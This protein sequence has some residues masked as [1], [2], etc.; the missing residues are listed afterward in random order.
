MEEASAP[1]PQKLFKGVAWDASDGRWRARV[2]LPEVQ[3]DG[4][5]KSVT[6]DAGR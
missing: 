2:N 5:T 6:V 3:P 4:S 1:R